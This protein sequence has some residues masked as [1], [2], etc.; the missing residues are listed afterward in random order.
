MIRDFSEAEKIRLIPEYSLQEFHAIE[1]EAVTPGQ[2][3]YMAYNG[4]YQS[5]YQLMTRISAEER[6]KFSNKYTLFETITGSINEL[7]ELRNHHVDSLVSREKKFLTEILDL[8]IEE[9]ERNSNYPKHLFHSILKVTGELRHLSEFNLAV[10]YLN[11]AITLG[12]NKYPELKVEVLFNLAEIFNRKGD[13]VSSRKYLD[14]LLLHPY[15]LTDRNR[16]AELLHNISQLYLKQGN[17][18]LYKNLL[19]L[20]LKYFYS[21]PE[22]RKKIFEQIRLT[23]RSS[24]RVLFKSDVTLLNRIVFFTHW[25][26]FKLPDLSK[27]KL[28]IINK[29]TLKVFLGFIYL[30]NYVQ[31]NKTAKSFFGN[32]NE[33]QN[34]LH[35]LRREDYRRSKKK[36]LFSA[37]KILITRAMGG[38]G[39]L[40]MMTPGIHALKMKYPDSEICLAI[41]GRYFP[42]FKGNNDVSLIDIEGDFFTHLEFDKWYNFTDCPAARKESRSAPKVRKSRIDIFASALNIGFLSRFKMSKKPRFFLTEDEKNFSS[43]FWSE[44]RLND[45]T[46]IGVQIH[47]D[48]T[49]RD[50]PLMEK[51]VEKLS[52]N[53][54]VM[55]FDNETI[56]GF[57]FEN[58]IKIQKFPIRK[59]FA[60]AQRC[61]AIIAPDSSFIHFAA[62]FDIPSI[63]L[64][65]PID[66]KVRTKHYPNCTYLSAKNLF[67]CMP[68]WRNESTPCKLT[69]MRTSECMKKIPVNEILQVL[70]MK[71]NRKM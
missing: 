60:L 27:F 42:V 38:I 37:K 12:V 52:E 34:S 4:D 3:L 9:C 13:L 65:G 20:G 69:G 8:F 6:K 23:Y 22:N 19:F 31:K 40:L 28:G 64:F 1:K 26:Y 67:G 54:T 50:Y 16:I 11:K 21:N 66:G 25:F 36:K 30:F 18:S 56:D 7:S 17:V 61:N 35:L 62:A 53:F 51:L 48:E 10:E 57:Q 24:L 41:P 14:Q 71:L 29:I 15:L 70:E 55:I 58:V 49:Y 44:F 2:L 47:S 5:V 43:E 59:A 39:D 68:C 32:L 45:K 33:N 46:V 63:A